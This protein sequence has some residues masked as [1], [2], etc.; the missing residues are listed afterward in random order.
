[1]NGEEMLQV[2]I[3]HPYCMELQGKSYIPSFGATLVRG[4]TLVHS[5]KMSYKSPWNQKGVFFR[6]CS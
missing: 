3:F 1:M 2:F 6:L 5:R 4:D